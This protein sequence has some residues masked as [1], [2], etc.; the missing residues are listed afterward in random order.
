MRKEE[1][2]TGFGKPLAPGNTAAAQCSRA[3][4]DLSSVQFS[5][6]Q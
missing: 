5:A 6:Y 4:T 3:S 1:V 2:Q